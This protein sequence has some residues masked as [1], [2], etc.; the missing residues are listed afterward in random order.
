MVNVG[1][2]YRGKILLKT[3]SELI[4]N[5]KNMAEFG[6]HLERIIDNWLSSIQKLRTLKNP[7]ISSKYKD[8]N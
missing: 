7:F 2:D 4:W 6:V 1:W 5:N 8:V 3:T